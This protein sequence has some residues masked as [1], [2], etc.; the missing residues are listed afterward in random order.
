MDEA[1]GVNGDGG[2]V[3]IPEVS[4]LKKKNE[5]TYRVY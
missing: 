5:Y 4:P 3:L 1:L 2:D